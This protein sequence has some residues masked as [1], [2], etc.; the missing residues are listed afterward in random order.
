[1]TPPAHTEDDN[2]LDI[3]VQRRRNKQAAKKF[4]R[5]LL[6]GLQYVPA[7]SSRISSKATA[8]PSA[9]YCPAWNIARVAICIIAVSTR[10]GQRASG[11]VACKGSNPPGMPSAFSPR[12]APSP[13]IFARVGIFWRRP[14]TAKRWQSDLRVGPRSLARSGL[15]IRIRRIGE[16]Y[17]LA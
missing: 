14:S 13:N 11:S 15:P 5:K 17:P 8:R 4:F 10:I 9:R 6:K 7:W 3:L 2:V 16:G 1:M 12:M